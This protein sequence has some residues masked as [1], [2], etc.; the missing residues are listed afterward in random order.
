[1]SHPGVLG[2][3]DRR[4]V[5]A[6]VIAGLGWAGLPGAEAQEAKRAGYLPGASSDTDP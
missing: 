6:G 2:S 5:L 4:A 3:I 1:M